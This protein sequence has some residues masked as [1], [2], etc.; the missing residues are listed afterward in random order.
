MNLKELVSAKQ[1]REKKKERMVIFSQ[2][3]K[4]KWQGFAAE[5]F[6]MGAAAEGRWDTALE[7]QLDL[8][9]AS[10]KK[11]N[12]LAWCYLTLMLQEEAMDEMDM[13]PDKNAHAIW[14]CL[15][16]EYKQSI[17]KVDAE[18]ETKLEQ[19][20][21]KPVI[22]DQKRKIKQAEQCLTKQ[23]KYCYCYI[24]LWNEGIETDNKEFERIDNESDE[25]VVNNNRENA[26]REENEET[27]EFPVDAKHDNDAEEDVDT[28]LKWM[29]GKSK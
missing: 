28:V 15:N 1:K 21:E 12:K 26:N 8:E 25:S 23:E 6:A 7:M 16:K 2:N 27:E 3:D 18:F 29:I 10:N 5:V 24:N 17:E 4:K 11:L 22:Y 19:E 13:I 14:L 9:V 20:S